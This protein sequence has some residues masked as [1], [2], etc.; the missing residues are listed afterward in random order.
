MPQQLSSLMD[1]EL[2]THS[3]EQAIRDCD[4]PEGT[5]AWACYHMIGEVLRERR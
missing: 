5:Q 1:G 3:S 2:G 4:S